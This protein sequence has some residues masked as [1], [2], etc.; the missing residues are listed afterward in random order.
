[1]STLRLQFYQTEEM[2]SINMIDPI[3]FRVDP[4]NTFESTFKLS[5]KT[6]KSQNNRINPFAMPVKTNFVEISTKSTN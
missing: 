5:K 3:Y 1:M 2:N 4:N 6:I